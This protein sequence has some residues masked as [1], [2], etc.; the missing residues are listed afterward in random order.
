MTSLARNRA[1]SSRARIAVYRRHYPATTIPVQA[2]E[3][4]AVVVLLVATP[5]TSRINKMARKC[6]SATLF[7]KAGK[8]EELKA[9]AYEPL[10]DLYRVECS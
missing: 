7:A 5:S 10:R 8:L 2:A 6:V 1:S 3:T 9:R 4:G